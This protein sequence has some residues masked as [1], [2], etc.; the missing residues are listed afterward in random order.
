MGQNGNCV[1]NTVRT[2]IRFILHFVSWLAWIFGKNCSIPFQL[3]WCLR[4]QSLTWPIY[5]ELQMKQ[6]FIT[7]TEFGKILRWIG[8]TTG[9]HV[10]WTRIKRHKCLQPWVTMFLFDIN[11]EK[12]A[13][14]QSP[15]QMRDPSS[16]PVWDR[17]RADW[18]LPH[19]PI[20]A[21]HSMFAKLSK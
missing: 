8:S 18:N 9:R 10:Y 17:Q 12:F 21:I 6:I 13:V 5:R 15:F 3:L 20:P 11:F 16:A 4:F 2:N 1:I 19:F 7:K 14:L